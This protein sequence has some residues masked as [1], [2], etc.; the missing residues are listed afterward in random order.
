MWKN[1]KRLKGVLKFLALCFVIISA[2]GCR[3]VEKEEVNIEDALIG[4]LITMD[5][6]EVENYYKNH[7]NEIENQKQYDNLNGERIYLKLETSTS[8]DEDGEKEW[9]YV[10]PQLNGLYAFNVHILRKSEEEKY[11][12]TISYGEGLYQIKN[13]IKKNDRGEITEET[14]DAT[15]FMNP[16]EMQNQTNFYLYEIYQTP[17]NQVYIN[18]DIVEKIHTEGS[19]KVVCNGTEE[20][21]YSYSYNIH[22]EKVKEVAKIQILQRD[23]NNKIINKNIYTSLNLPKKLKTTKETESLVVEKYYKDGKKKERV[24]RKVY[25]YEEEEE[26]PIYIKRGDGIYREEDIE[27]EWIR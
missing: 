25:P 10:F 2:N 8:N 18:C 12:K 21:L 15:I 9:N 19:G 20:M 4:I 5:E 27:I 1:K 16:E 11:M 14:L 6:K 23:K 22:F 17:E 26:I 24:E 13:S 7:K 3:R